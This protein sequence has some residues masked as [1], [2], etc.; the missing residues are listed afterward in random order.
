MVGWP[1]VWERTTANRQ[2]MLDRS[3]QAKVY[4]CDEFS[5]SETLVYYPGK[6]KSLPD[7]SQPYSVEA[8]NAELRQ[9]L[10]RLARKSRCFSRC[11]Q[12]LW[13]SVNLLGFAWNRPQ[14]YK[15]RFPAYPAH[16]RNSL[17]P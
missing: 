1:V 8:H 17:Y 14:L 3:P 7:K 12:A 4:Y 10:A 11:I 15:P 16:L 6:H 2:A 9:S 5:T 13:R